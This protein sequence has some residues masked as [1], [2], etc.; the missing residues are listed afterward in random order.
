MSKY[1]KLICTFTHLHICTS[2]HL[3]IKKFAHLLAVSIDDIEYH[4]VFLQLRQIIE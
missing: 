4:L 2:S 3:H 1:A